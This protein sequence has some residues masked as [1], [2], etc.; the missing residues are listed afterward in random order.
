VINLA[1][2]KDAV[3]AE[4]HRVLRPGGRRRWSRRRRTLSW[5]P[6]HEGRGHNDQIL[7]EAIHLV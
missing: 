2:D 4:A 3:F 6:R 5:R 7:D 1:A